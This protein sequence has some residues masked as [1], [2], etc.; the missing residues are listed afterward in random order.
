MDSPIPPP[1]PP[2]DGPPVALS[3]QAAKRVGEATRYVEKIRRG[4]KGE[5]GRTPR[6]AGNPGFWAWIPPAGGTNP[7]TGIAYTGIVTGSAGNYL[8]TGYVI[9]CSRAATVLTADQET[10]VVYNGGGQISTGTAGVYVKLG[11]TDGDWSVDVAPCPT[12]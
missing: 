6:H 3:S 1:M 11:W 2:L 10:V 5:D 7:L 12:S 8:G 9:L 4:G